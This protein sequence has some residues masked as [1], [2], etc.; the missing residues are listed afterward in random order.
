MTLKTEMEKTE[1]SLIKR[2]TRNV[3][4]RSSVRLSSAKTAQLRQQGAGARSTDGS[5]ATANAFHRVSEAF[6]EKRRIFSE[7][8]AFVG[9][10]HSGK[11]NKRPSS[12]VPNHSHVSAI[13]GCMF[14]FQAVIVSF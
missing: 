8:R 10:R 3:R 4:W 11:S 1:L 2:R 9:T 13:D 5:G 6:P 14:S 12:S 7:K